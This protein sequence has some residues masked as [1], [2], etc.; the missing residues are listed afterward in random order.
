[1]TAT[2][3]YRQYVTYV[4]YDGDFE[5]STQEFTKDGEQISR[6]EI[7]ASILDQ[8]DTRV[9]LRIYQKVGAV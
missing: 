3:R 7:P 8:L 5:N 2:A 4:D 1:M 9:Q 6:D